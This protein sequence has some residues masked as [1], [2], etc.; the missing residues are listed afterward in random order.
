MTIMTYHEITKQQWEV[1]K[2]KKVKQ[3]G[4]MK[5]QKQQSGP[6]NELSWPEP[7][8]QENILTISFANT[9]SCSPSSG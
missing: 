7:M 9:S 8:E 5:A 4:T 6:G 2:K 1:F 3:E